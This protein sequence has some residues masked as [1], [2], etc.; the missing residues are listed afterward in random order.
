MD[1]SQRV[2][3]RGRDRETHIDGLP[4]ECIPTRAMPATEAHALDRNQTRAP[5]TRR[6]TLPPLSRASRAGVGVGVPRRSS[7]GWSWLECEAERQLA[8]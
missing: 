4:P 6:P 1:L 7:P 2:E 8:D 3:G 5:A